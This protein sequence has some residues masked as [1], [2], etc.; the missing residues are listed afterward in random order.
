VVEPDVGFDQC[1]LLAGYLDRLQLERDA[2]VLVERGDPIA[3]AVIAAVLE[4]RAG[5]TRSCRTDQHVD[6]AHADQHVWAAG[7][8]RGEPEAHQLTDPIRVDFFLS[9]ACAGRLPG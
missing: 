4:R 6:V 1:G 9:S 2:R 7:A 5:L 8:E 3:D